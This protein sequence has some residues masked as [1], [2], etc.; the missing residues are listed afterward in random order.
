[1][2]CLKK[3]NT[4]FI[5]LILLGST[6]CKNEDASNK[7]NQQQISSL[8]EDVSRL[9]EENRRL[10]QEV[11]A[12]RKELTARTEVETQTSTTSPVKRS[13]SMTVDNMKADVE[14]LLR[15]LIQKL[16]KRSETPRKDDQFG[17]RVEYDLKRAVYGL[18]RNDD[19]EVPYHARIIVPYEKFVESD[20]RSR[21]YGKGIT[22][23]LF[24][25]T[26]KHWQLQSYQ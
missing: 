7:A 16:K 18:V 17:M 19:P 11:S 25:Y 14:P 9:A 20:Q 21:S 15:D 1:V 5:V 3:L 22:T 24:A 10:G 13:E 2:T 4:I 6:Y 12:L 23:V 8:R 26:G